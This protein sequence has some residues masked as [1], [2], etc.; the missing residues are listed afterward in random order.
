MGLTKRLIM[1]MIILFIP[2]LA[3]AQE[4]TLADCISISLEQ[5][6]KIKAAKASVDVS[7][8]DKTSSLISA[9]PSASFG[10][11]YLKLLYSNTPELDFNGTKF[12]LDLPAWSREVSVTVNQPVTPLY[13]AIKGYD[14]KSILVEIE[15]TK[16]LLTKDQISS[17]VI[18]LYYSY[19]ILRGVSSLLKESD[20]LLDKYVLLSKSFIDNEMSDR[21][22]LYKI[23]IQKAKNERETEQVKGGMIVLKKAL[24][25]MMNRSADSFELAEKE[26]QTPEVRLSADDI[27]RQQIESRGE[28]KILSKAETVYHKMSDIYIQPLIPMVNLTASYTRSFDSSMFGAENTYVVGAVMSWEVGL[29][30]WRNYENFKKAKSEELKAALENV[31]ARKQME[32]Q[33]TQMYSALKVKEKEIKIADSE[34]RSATENLRIEENKYS[35]NM[36]TQTELLNAVVALKSAKS[37]LINARYEYEKAL[38]ILARTAGVTKEQLTEKNKY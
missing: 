16:E 21:R 27:A 28:F 5:S 22:S 10:M 34:I 32:L 9:F 18:D 1:I 11:K 23:E 38:E 12:P 14:M 25:L 17:S 8:H 20:E 31:E 30:W 4:L 24:S 26:A 35:Q 33:I 7:A 15:K 37:G 6:E 36:T 19:Q 3:A 29:D 13:A 2:L